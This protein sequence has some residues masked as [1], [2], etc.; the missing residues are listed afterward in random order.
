VL[1]HGGEQGH[2]QQGDKVGEATVFGLRSL[3]CRHHAQFSV[4]AHD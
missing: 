1:G 2:Q 3:L 4:S